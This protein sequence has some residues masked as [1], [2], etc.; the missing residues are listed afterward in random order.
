MPAPT[1]SPHVAAT[2]HCPRCW[3]DLKGLPLA[4]KC[5]ECGST[6]DREVAAQN[7]AELDRLKTKL[8]SQ[9]A[10]TRQ[11]FLPSMPSAWTIAIM[12]LAFGSAAT[13]IAI[14]WIAFQ[15]FEKAIGWPPV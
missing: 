14:A 11:R 10:A 13:L 3:Y 9:E 12:V 8:E 15:K 4:G 1:T 6:Y 7:A 5:P 2:R